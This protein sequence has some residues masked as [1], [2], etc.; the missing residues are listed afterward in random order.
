MHDADRVPSSRTINAVILD[1]F[2]DS[3]ASLRLIGPT[4]FGYAHDGL[5]RA[6]SRFGPSP[7]Q[8][9]SVTSRPACRRRPRYPRSQSLGRHLDHR[10][11]TSRPTVASGMAAPVCMTLPTN[12]EHGAEPAA[13]WKTRKSSAVKPRLSSSAIASASPSACCIK[14][15]VVGARLCGQASR[16]C[17]KAR[18]RRQ[19]GQASVREGVRRLSQCGTCANSRQVLEL[20]GLARPDSA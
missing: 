14:V 15:D 12:L 5:D 4:V 8:V 9:P 3:S 13:R 7:A 11:R 20:G 17:G 2:D 6:S 18:P 1:E 19:L 16:A 10:P